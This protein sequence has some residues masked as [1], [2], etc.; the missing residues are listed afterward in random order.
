MLLSWVFLYYDFTS[1]T[2]CFLEY[3]GILNLLLVRVAFLSI[4]VLWFYFCYVLLYWVFWYYDF[5]SGTCWFI[6]YSGILILLLVRVPFLS[7][8]V[9]WYYFWCVFLF[10]VFWYF[11]I[12][13]DVVLFL[14]CW[15]LHLPEQETI[16]DLPSFDILLGITQ[17]IGR[18]SKVSAILFDLVA[19]LVLILWRR[20]AKL[21]R[22]H[23]RNRTSHMIENI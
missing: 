18:R 7:I 11:D 17:T 22:L 9:F 21:F 14:F 6:E 20:K 2:C 10:W 12:S 15:C 8:L 1:G 16:S 23:I 13:S 4:L 3:S 19:F 5:T